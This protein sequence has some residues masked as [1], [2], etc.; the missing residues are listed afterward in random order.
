M[1]QIDNLIQTQAVDGEF[2]TLMQ[3]NRRKLVPA[4]A[5]AGMLAGPS[6]AVAGAVAG[7]RILSDGALPQAS[8]KMHA[9]DSIDGGHPIT[10]HGMEQ[11]ID[12]I[13]E[14]KKQDINTLSQFH[15]S[16][17]WH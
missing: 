4:L 10:R 3:G 2:L 8:G 16:Q 7:H 15:R 5:G 17:Q 14:Q 6:W 12:G 11:V 9:L 13:E 1:I